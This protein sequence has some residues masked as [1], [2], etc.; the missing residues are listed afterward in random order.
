MVISIILIILLCYAFGF[1]PLGTALRIV[2]KIGKLFFILVGLWAI[3]MI[4]LCVL[5]LI[6]GS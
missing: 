4:V 1:S 5:G 6:V 3:L 2:K